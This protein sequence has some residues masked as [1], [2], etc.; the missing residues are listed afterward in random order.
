MQFR[1]ARLAATAAG[2]LLTAL[3]VLAD[4]AESAERSIPSSER[5]TASFDGRAHWYGGQFNGRRT[6]SGAIFDK[7]KLT[8]AHPSLPFGTKV[9]VHSKYSGRDV[10]V[11]ITDRCPA[12]KQ[13]C[14]DVSEGA[15][16][17]LGI[18]PYAP[19]A[20]HCEVLSAK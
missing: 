14:I 11:T 15:A 6:A 7:K 13:R 17:K 18:Y 2:I 1:C 19:C 8:A 20:V 10:V 5:A 16:R 12:L 4:S 3:P 9:K